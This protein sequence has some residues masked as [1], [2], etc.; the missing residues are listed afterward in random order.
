VRLDA[1]AWIA[2][3]GVIVSLLAAAVAVHQARSAQKAL[4]FAREPAEA[5][6]DQ[7]HSA[8]DAAR[9]AQ[10]A[11][12][13]TVD[14]ARTARESLAL[15]RSRQDEADRPR[16]DVSTEPPAPGRGPATRITMT[17]GPPVRVSIDWSGSVIWLAPEGPQERM[18]FTTKHISMV[19]NQSTTLEPTPHEQA[20]MVMG[21]LKI[22]SEE[23]G[24]SGRRW[25]EDQVV[26]WRQF[27]ADPVS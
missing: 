23:I 14:A 4:R 26:D 18:D 10:V 13:A 6:K 20:E 27:R 2:I 15:E 8:R 22:E 9:A 25:S 24:G 17:Q 19:K 11:T 1:A 21:H 3:A 12:D 16:F 7:A 5:A